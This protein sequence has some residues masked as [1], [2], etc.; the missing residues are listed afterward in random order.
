ML[1]DI[2]THTLN[3]PPEVLGVDDV[4]TAIYFRHVSPLPSPKGARS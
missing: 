1:Q 4:A 3:P 2:F